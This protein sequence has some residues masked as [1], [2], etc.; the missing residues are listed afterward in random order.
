MSWRCITYVT[1]LCEQDGYTPL[2]E[3]FERGNTAAAE[4]LLLVG[5]DK[6]PIKKVQQ[7]LRFLHTHMY[8]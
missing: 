6:R 5:A 3:A 1:M 8:Q 2:V 7:T 4:A